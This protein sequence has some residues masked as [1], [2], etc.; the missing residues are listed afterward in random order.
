M[1]IFYKI[2]GQSG[3]K[4]GDYETLIKEAISSWNKIEVWSFLLH[5]N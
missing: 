1:H 2:E 3:L 4:I 5:E